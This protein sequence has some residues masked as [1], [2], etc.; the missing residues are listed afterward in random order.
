MYA[1]KFEFILLFHFLDCVYWQSISSLCLVI[2]FID[3]VYIHLFLT[4]VSYS[5][6]T[7]TQY[8]HILFVIIGTVT[9]HVLSFI[10]CLQYQKP[11]PHN[12]H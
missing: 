10:K 5:F 6:I 1:F 3:I 2:L 11:G 7:N 8:V 12:K 9:L 4:A